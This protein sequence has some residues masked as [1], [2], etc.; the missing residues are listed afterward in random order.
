MGKRSQFGM[1]EES[2]RIKPEQVIPLE[3]RDF[4]EF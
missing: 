3:G 2:L 1:E 4:K